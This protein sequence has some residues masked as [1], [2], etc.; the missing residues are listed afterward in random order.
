MPD[1]L[2]N[3][4]AHMSWADSA[5]LAALE[6]ASTPDTR[7]IELYSHIL[8]AEHVWFSRLQGTPAQV[9]V[10]PTLALPDC[11]RLAAENHR[12]FSEYAAALTLADRQRGIRYTNSAG[13]EFT[14]TVEDILLHVCLHGSYHRGQI[15]SAMRSGSAIPRPTDYI[16]FTRGAPA[17][18]RQ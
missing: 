3:L 2:E 1:Y 15:A 16:S 18:T 13:Q 8:G 4:L 11:R 10:W 5:V 12:R 17:A 9:A 14:S 6:A 7:W